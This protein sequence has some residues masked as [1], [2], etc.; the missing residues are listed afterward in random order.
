MIYHRMFFIVISNV[1]EFVGIFFCYSLS[2]AF[3]C[4][5]VKQHW[6]GEHYQEEGH[7]G[8]DIAKTNVPDIRVSFRHETLLE[9][10]RIL[11]SGAKATSSPK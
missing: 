9:E 2:N 6:L 7:A 3:C 8:N 1:S 10:L 4:S 5:K 11:E